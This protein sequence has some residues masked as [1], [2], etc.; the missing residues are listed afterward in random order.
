MRDLDDLG[1]VLAERQLVAADGN[2]DGITQ[3]RNLADVDLN[4]LRDAHVHDAALDSAFA[5]ELDDLDGRADLGFF[6][7]FHVLSP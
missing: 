6:Q 1:V 4:A 3:R 7:R 2:L 5:G